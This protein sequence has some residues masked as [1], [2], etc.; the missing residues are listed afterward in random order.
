MTSHHEYLPAIRKCPHA[1]SQRS[2]T[3]ITACS[4]AQKAQVSDSSWRALTTKAGRLI[5]GLIVRA[6]N[7]FLCGTKVFYLA[8]DPPQLLLHYDHSQFAFTGSIPTCDSHLAAHAL[9]H[10][11][12]F[13]SRDGEA[14]QPTQVVAQ[15][16]FASS[17]FVLPSVHVQLSVSSPNRFSRNLGDTIP[18]RGFASR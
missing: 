1:N 8:Y 16:T 17:A 4:A 15:R 7:D 3:T 18:V 14:L 10:R 12:M 2:S 13:R 11:M 5:A 9:F 6:F